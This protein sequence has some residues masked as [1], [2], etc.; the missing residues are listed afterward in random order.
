MGEHTVKV[1]KLTGSCILIHVVEVEVLVNLLLAVKWRR[2]ACAAG[3]VIGLSECSFALFEVLVSYTINVHWVP[4]KLAAT[5]VGM[6]VECRNNATE[7][8]CYTLATQRTTKKSLEERTHY[9]ISE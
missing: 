2:E 7:S 1:R 6:S 3:E 4:A 5:I 8:E 9:V